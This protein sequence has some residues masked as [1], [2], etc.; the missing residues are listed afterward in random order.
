MK[1]N[2]CAMFNT[3]SSFLRF[4]P[5]NYSFA[6][7]FVKN[8]KLYVLGKFLFFQSRPSSSVVMYGEIDN[9]CVSCQL[10]LSF[11]ILKSAAR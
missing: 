10:S 4:V 3:T 8:S 1:I 7:K 6:R 9:T 11:D 2:I 5:N